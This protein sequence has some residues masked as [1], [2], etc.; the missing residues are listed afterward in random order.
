MTLR[1]TLRLIRS[2][3]VR[4]ATHYQFEL[5]VGRAIGMTILPSLIALILHR[6]AHYLI[7]SRLSFLAWP[8]YSLNIMV[9]GA[10]IVP[11]SS[12]GPGCLLGH[13]P[14][15]II[16]AR[17]GRNATFL[18][19][20]GI[21]GGRNAVDIGAGPGLPVLG[22]NV[23]VCANGIVM[24]AVTIGDGAVIGACALTLIDVPP[25]ATVIGIPGRIVASRQE[26]PFGPPENWRSAGLSPSLPAIGSTAPEITR[27]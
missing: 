13:A 8:V 23:T 3:Y 15:M 21:G 14:G 17:V 11:R 26:T 7:N 1:E 2:D 20:C 19:R 16:S 12:I 22:D 24:G 9:T 25:G 4:M 10:D 18:A 6:I 27:T 5:T